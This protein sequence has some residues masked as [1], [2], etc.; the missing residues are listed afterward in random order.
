M[1]STKYIGMDVHKESISIA[2]RNDAGKLVME[3]VIE[4]KANAILDFIHG[5]RGELHITFEEGTWAAWLYDLQKPHITKLVVIG[6]HES[7]IVN[8]IRVCGECNSRFGHSFEAEATRQLKRMQVFGLAKDTPAGR[9]TAIRSKAEARFNPF[10]DSAGCTIVM[11]WQRRLRIHSSGDQTLFLVTHLRRGS[12]FLRAWFADRQIKPTISNRRVPAEQKRNP[13]LPGTMIRRT[14]AE[15]IDHW[16]A[17]CDGGIA[18][19][20]QRLDHHWFQFE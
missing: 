11:R 17:S 19:R 4:T 18:R 16:L 6:R 20:S 7:G 14:T 10:R 5:L 1:T 12:C 3:C 8:P 2:V 13:F 15:R 9:P